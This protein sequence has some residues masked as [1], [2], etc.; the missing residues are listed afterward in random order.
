M[1]DNRSM[2]QLPISQIRDTGRSRDNDEREQFP[3]HNLRL[4]RATRCI[5]CSNAKQQTSF[6]TYRALKDN[7][8]RELKYGSELSINLRNKSLFVFK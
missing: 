1:I 8:M 4:D 5:E 7:L 3:R 6:A 2:L